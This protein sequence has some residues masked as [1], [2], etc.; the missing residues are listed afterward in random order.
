MARSMA[1]RCQLVLAMSL[2]AAVPANADI[3]GG[4]ATGDIEFNLGGFGTLLSVGPA[5]IPRNPGS[6]A[7]GPFGLAG[8][9]GF[10]PQ[11]W[12]FNSNA[13]YAYVPMTGL[14]AFLNQAEEGAGGGTLAEL[15]ASFSVDFTIDVSGTQASSLGMQFAIGGLVGASGGFA[16]FEFDVN[17]V[18]SVDGFQGNLSGIFATVAPGPISSGLSDTL[19]LPAQTSGTLTVSGFFALRVDDAAGST[20]T[21]IGIRPIP[22]PNTL[23]LACL[24]AGGMAVWRWRRRQPAPVDA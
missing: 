22:E 3:T 11:T 20:V 14:T 10:L 15:I 19:H 17:F 23:A 8:S 2:A 24:A 13:G 4:V 16:E 12:D 5:P 18:H 7:L 9:A 6:Q 21:E 1:S